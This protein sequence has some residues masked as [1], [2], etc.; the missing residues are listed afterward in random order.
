MAELS[1]G[2][3]GRLAGGLAGGLAWVVTLGQQGQSNTR[4]HACHQHSGHKNLPNS[5]RA[6]GPPKNLSD[7]RDPTITA[8]ACQN[9][10]CGESRRGGPDRWPP[11]R[12]SKSGAPSAIMPNVRQHSESSAVK[13]DCPPARGWHALTTRNRQVSMLCMPGWHVPC[14]LATRR[15]AVRLSNACPGTQI[16][17]LPRP[18]QPAKGSK[19]QQPVPNERRES[20]RRPKA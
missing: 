10:C 9:P 14:S 6:F 16:T 2:L 11:P 5:V 8:R 3:V 19:M 15:D 12:G 13:T 18:Q 7:G 20:W 4:A 17:R 1:T